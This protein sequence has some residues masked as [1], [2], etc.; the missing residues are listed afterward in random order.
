[1]KIK[2]INCNCVV[3]EGNIREGKKGR[4]VFDIEGE[5]KGEIW[6]QGSKNPRDWVGL[7]SGCQKKK[8]PLSSIL[9]SKIN[10]EDNGK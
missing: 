1:M 4:K 8:K 5:C 9:K 2:C 6:K 3:C 7:C 10:G